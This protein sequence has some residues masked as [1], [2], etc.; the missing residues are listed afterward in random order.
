MKCFLFSLLALFF[1]S[2]AHNKGVEV[3][4]NTDKTNLLGYI[5]N[6]EN[7]QTKKPGILIVHEWWGHNDYARTRADMLAKEGYV[8]MA[9][10]MYGNGKQADHPKKAGEFSSAVFKDFKEARARFEAAI[11]TLKRHPHVDKEKI[12]AIGYC[13]GGGIV[14]S[15]AKTGLPLQ[16]VVSYHGSLDS[17]VKPQKGDVKAKVLVFNGGK[18]PMVTESAI[19]SFKK[20]MSRVGGELTFINFPDAVH[21][22]TNPEATKLGK[23]FNLPL[24]YDKKADEESWNKTLSFFKEIF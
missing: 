11:N 3:N 7:G 9:V 1:F 2:C 22:F 10:D 6:V 16:G 12:A 17:P 5:A 4:Y 18:D 14:L 19:K 20:E 15:M 23:K 13:F 21:A 8:A 24:A